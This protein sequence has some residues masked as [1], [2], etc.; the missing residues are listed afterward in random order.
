MKGNRNIFYTPED[1]YPGMPHGEMCGDF[2]PFFYDGSFYLFY[3]YKYCVYTVQTKDFVSFGEPYLVIQNGSPEDQ[4][5]H[6][7]TGSVFE[8][9]GVFYF[10]YTGF[11]EGSDGIEGKNEQVVMRAL[12]TDLK[13]WKKDSSFALKPD[14]R[15]FG[16]RHW[17]DPHVFW[18]EDLQKF[19]MLITATEK[20]GAYQ[21]SGCS[22]V[23][24]S[25]DVKTWEYYKILYAPRT[26]ITHECHDCFK[27]G[28]K[29]YLSFSNYS[30]WW[31]TRYRIADRFEGPWQVPKKDDMFDGRE[32][33]AA[34]SVSDGKKRYMVGWESIREN[35]KDSGRHLWGGNLLV[36]ELQQRED[37][38][39]GVKLPE[40]IEHSFGKILPVKAEVI[41]GIL[42]N[43]EKQPS[44]GAEDGFGWM[45]FAELREICLF[46]T[47]ITWD[48]KTQATGIMI[49]ADD[50][51]KQWC[52]LRLEIH[53]G[54][55]LMDRYNRVDGDQSYEDE[56]PITFKDNS[57]EIKL[58]VSGN[59]MLVYVDD[60]AL[61]SRCYE[62]G[63]GSVGV[64]TEYGTVCCTNTELRIQ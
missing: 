40:T 27:M 6:I 42:S 46:R 19:S 54:K 4:D 59:I 52:Q 62:I 38:S 58:V 12:S 16:N 7:G 31:E 55:I 51:L 28:E 39:L 60:V 21:R 20:E 56:R 37:G 11:C 64:F 25:D 9:G 47:R 41:Q 35:C 24:V 36:H 13:N 29:W 44:L 49:H 22:A 57:A 8:H 1:Q 33:Y 15:Y 34:K 3:L 53:H 14:T 17:R 32:Y 61:V 23:F 45:K 2:M 18:N 43:D 26:F 10:H 30:R 63:T 50:D 48:E 5:W